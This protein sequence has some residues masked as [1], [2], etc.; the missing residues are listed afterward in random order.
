MLLRTSQQSCSRCG[1]H[2]VCQLQAVQR[3]CNCAALHQW[4]D[5]GLECRRQ[6]AALCSRH[7]RTQLHTQHAERMWNACATAV[8]VCGCTQAAATSSSPAPAA[9]WAICL[10][11]AVQQ[12][13]GQ[14]LAFMMCSLQHHS[15]CAR[16]CIKTGGVFVS[17]A[18]GVCCVTFMCL[19]YIWQIMDWSHWCSVLVTVS[20]GHLHVST[21][22]S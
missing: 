21:S 9:C 1:S 3:R 8:V 7:C 15:R 18:H 14:R 4:C 12:Q 13:Q 11:P 16:H 10:G 17:H 22:T 19:G 5:V 6:G 2:A 20:A